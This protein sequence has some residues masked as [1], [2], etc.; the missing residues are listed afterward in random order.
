MTIE[1]IS[2]TNSATWPLNVPVRTARALTRLA[3]V[4]ATLVLL[5]TAFALGRWTADAGTP[6]HSPAIN[7]PAG[8]SAAPVPDCRPHG[9]C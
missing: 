8:G 3:V 2:M 6:S 1:G 5:A 4:V 9:Y 7:A